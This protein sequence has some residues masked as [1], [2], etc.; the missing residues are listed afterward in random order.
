MNFTEKIAS[1]IPINPSFHLYL[2]NALAWFLI[3][4]F[5]LFCSSIQIKSFQAICIRMTASTSH[6]V[7]VT[8]QFSLYHI[9]IAFW[10][11]SF[12]WY[13]PV[14]ISDVEVI[15]VMIQPK[16]F[17][18]KFLESGKS[19]LFPSPVCFD[20]NLVSSPSS[21]FRVESVR[22]TMQPSWK[23]KCGSN[24]KGRSTNVY[25]HPLI[26][27]PPLLLIVQKL[28]GRMGHGGDVAPNS[29]SCS[30]LAQGCAQAYRCFCIASKWEMKFTHNTI[31]K[32]AYHVCTLFMRVHKEV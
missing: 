1:I 12:G 25:T 31:Q 17:A 14:W 20:S 27:N 13:L 18:Q 22:G 23:T 2:C 16:S 26:E 19:I 8:K 4:W 32:P 28:Q 10:K 5:M 21:E 24:G 9:F 6:I 7:K 3:L 15:Y 30:E 29:D 11:L